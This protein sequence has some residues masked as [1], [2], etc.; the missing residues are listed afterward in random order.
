[1]IQNPKIL[2]LDEATSSIDNETEELIQQATK[3]LLQGR[4]SIVVA[5]RLATIRNADMILVMEKGRIKEVGKH[6]ELLEKGGLYRKL[7]ELQFTEL[8]LGE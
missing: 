3:V 2:I 5:H 4:T 7:Y 8:V 6:D 1:M